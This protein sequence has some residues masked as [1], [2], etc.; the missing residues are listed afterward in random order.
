MIN[1]QIILFMIDT[2][3]LWCVIPSTTMVFVTPHYTR[4]AAGHNL[5]HVQC[6]LVSIHHLYQVVSK[7]STDEILRNLPALTKI[8][9]WRSQET[10]FMEWGNPTHSIQFT[11]PQIFDPRMSH[12]PHNK[13]KITSQKFIG[14][15]VLT[16]LWWDR[17]WGHK[18]SYSHINTHL[19]HTLPL[20]RINAST[21][22]IFLY[23]LNNSLSTTD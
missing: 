4:H 13:F 1:I 21:I 16:F 20:Q 22:M 10:Q 9:A 11:V 2:L 15:S 12:M 6:T 7:C 23:Y 5:W 8:P 19:V 14:N 17:G 18:Y 3:Q